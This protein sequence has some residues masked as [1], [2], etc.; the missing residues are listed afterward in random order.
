MEDLDLDDILTKNPHLDEAALKARQKA[1]AKQAA[2]RNRARQGPASPY[3]QRKDSGGWDEK[4]EPAY[5]SHYR[6]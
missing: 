6:G 2:Q 4:V 3:G 1:A 5:R